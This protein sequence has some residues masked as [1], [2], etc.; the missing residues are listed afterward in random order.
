MANVKNVLEKLK[1]VEKVENIQ[2]AQAVAS[3]ENSEEN[4]Y[5]V[6]DSVTDDY[7]D[8]QEEIDFGDYKPPTKKIEEVVTP[9]KAI[10]DKNLSV[11]EIY[12]LNRIENGPLNTVF[13]L[14]NFINALPQNL[15]YDVKKATVIN[16]VNASSS[17]LEQLL[18]EGETRVRVLNSFMED[19]QL[20]LSGNINEYK[21]EIL[22]LTKQIDHFKVLIHDKETL[23]E[24]QK[25]VI[26]YE[27]QKINN[28]IDFFNHDNKY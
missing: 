1:L 11:N 24:E 28:I 22:K 23:L 4:Q 9:Q 14:E 8:E 20:S 21:T 25:N 19:F 6:N 10:M 26:K 12:A 16:I 15:P 27:S 17:N 5:F 7:V 3:S 18:S 2:E 13:L